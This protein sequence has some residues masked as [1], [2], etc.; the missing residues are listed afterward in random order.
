MGQAESPTTEEDRF[1]VRHIPVYMDRWA[2]I[3]TLDIVL[4]EKNTNNGQVIC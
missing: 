1:L 2:G 4:F 3:Q